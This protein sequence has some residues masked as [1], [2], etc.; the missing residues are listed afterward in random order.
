MYEAL[1]FRIRGVVPTIM[2]NGQTS[3]PL[4]FYAKEMKKLTSKRNKTDYIH[5]QLAKL[6]WFAALYVDDKGRPAWPG[7]N[8]E[9][10]IIAAAKKTKNGQ[11]AKAGLFVYGNF[12]LLYEGPK[13]AER[14]WDHKAVEKNP[15]VSRVSVVVNRNRVM[16][17]RPIFIDWQL[18]FI[19][20]YLPTVLTE[21]QIIEFIN[22]AG[23][24]VGLSDWRPKYGRFTVLSH[25]RV[26]PMKAKAKPQEIEPKPEEETVEPS[27]QPVQQ[28][29][30]AVAHSE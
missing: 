12:P 11:Q 7:E 19:V 16:R 2:H 24:V 5:L 3:D 1:K 26:T 9:S 23:I 25:E 29:E 20:H 6:E 14:L 18:D 13:S 8:I 10:M 28:E 15:F 17:T 4:N 27:E 30:P 22:T 21:E